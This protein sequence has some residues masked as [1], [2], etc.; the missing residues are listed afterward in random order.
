MRVSV[1][2]PLY[3][4]AAT[5][6][7]AL[8][9]IARQSFAGFEAIVVDDGSTDGGGEIAEKFSDPR[10]RVVRQA[11]AGP[12]AA[13]NRGIAE[14]GGELIAF[15][16][17]DDAWLPEYLESGV[18]LMEAGGEPVASVTSGYLDFPRGVSTEDL[19]RRRGIAEGVH[20][21]TPST[22]AGALVSMLAYMSPCSTMARLDRVRRWGGFYEKDGCRYG[23]DALLWLKFL[24]NERVRF[25]MRPLAEF[26]REASSLSSNYRLARPVEPFLLDPDEVASAC[27]SDLLPLLRRF[28]A[29]RAAKTAAVLGYWGDWKGARRVFSRFVTA[30]DWRMPYFLPGLV[31]CTPLAG[32]AGAGLR[33]LRSSA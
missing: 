14:A 16:D 1:V 6:A 29:A 31:G 18:R 30:G 22:P 2:V 28:Y 11:N 19:W 8:D 21:V 20:R 7:R 3:N 5:V 10:F 24:L 23:E 13:R 15:L 25:V 33:L 26:H 32:I 12:G 27:P 9:S 4:K 17:A